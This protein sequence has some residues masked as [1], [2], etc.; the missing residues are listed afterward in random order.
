[1]LAILRMRVILH[2]SLL[3][4]TA[5]WDCFGGQIWPPSS[6]QPCNRPLPSFKNPH[7]QNEARC[8]TFLVKMSFICMRMKNDFHIKGWAPTLVLKQRPG[9]TRKW[10]IVNERGVSVP[11][12]AHSAIRLS[13]DPVSRAKWVVVDCKP[14]WKSFFILMQIKLIFTRKVV[15]LASFWKWGFMELGSGLLAISEFPRASEPFNG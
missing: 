3:C 15:H 8:T 6:A 14:I 9:G 11:K 2:G 4:W 5:W 10:P 7:F 12:H 13:T 1:M